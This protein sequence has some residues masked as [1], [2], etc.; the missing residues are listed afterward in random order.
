MVLSNIEQQVVIE[1]LQVGVDSWK[2]QVR[3]FFMY[4]FEGMQN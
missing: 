3:N 4:V 2:Y 1:V